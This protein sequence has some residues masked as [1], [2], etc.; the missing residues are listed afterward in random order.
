MRRPL[1][2]LRGGFG[3]GALR[4]VEGLPASAEGFEEPD[5]V[6]RDLSAA[7]DVLLGERAQRALRAYDVRELDEAVGVFP[8]RDVDGGR[9]LSDAAL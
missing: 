1:F 3:Y 7:D 5:G 2:F 4:F 9:R 6:G 8:V